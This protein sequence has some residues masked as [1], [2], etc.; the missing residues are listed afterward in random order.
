[1]ASVRCPGCGAKNPEGS[2]KCRICGYDLR[3][4]SELPMSQP[5]AGSAEIRSGSLKGV[6]ALAVLGVLAIV[7]AGVLL[8]VIP[9][10]DVI[11]EARNKVPF[12]ATQS[13]D[14]WEEFTE[15]SARFA[16]TM[17][18]DRTQAQEAFAASTTGMADEWVSTLGPDDDPDTTLSIQWAPVTPAAEDT[19]EAVLTST[20]IAWANSLG[21]KIG[22]DSATSFQ[23]QP[24]LLV[25]VE[26]LRNADG[27]KVT[28]RALFVLQ[29]EQLFLIESR[30]I[31]ADHPQFD[32]LVNGFALL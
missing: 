4:H 25:Q 30:S 29:R 15:P 14:G 24:A 16:A 21:G 5:K 18:V 17:P 32:R 22:D 20:A 1:M 3:G 9:G 7:L 8:G 26:E 10:G 11:T 2:V 13:S 27:D 31:Y 19:E 6:L 12:L 23:G 28:V